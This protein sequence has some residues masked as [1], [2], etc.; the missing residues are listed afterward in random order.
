MD[1]GQIL[2]DFKQIFSFGNLDLAQTLE[3]ATFP[4]T[5]DK[6]LTL[7]QGLNRYILTHLQGH[8]LAIL[9][10]CHLNILASL[11]LEISSLLQGLHLQQ[12]EQLPR[13]QQAQVH[14]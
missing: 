14:H 4:G 3:E 8:N 6:L 13:L 1:L 10:S 5:L 9:T 12:G 11:H 2:E 7:L